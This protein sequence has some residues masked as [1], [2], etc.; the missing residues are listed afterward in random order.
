VVISKEFG[1]AMKMSVVTTDLPLIY[2]QK[3]DLGVEDFA[4]T[5]NLR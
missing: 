4:G 3:R 2:D 1:S 5:V